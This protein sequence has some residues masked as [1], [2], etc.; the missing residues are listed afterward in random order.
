M[1]I[2]FNNPYIQ[3]ILIAFIAALLAAFFVYLLKLIKKSGSQLFSKFQQRKKEETGLEI[4][5]CTLEEKTL[6]ISHPWMKEDQTLNGILVPINFEMR[7]V[8]EREE[9]EIYVKSL[10]RKKSAPRLLILG[11]PG[12]GKTIAMRVIAR[13]MWSI[14][15]KIRLVPVILNFSDIKN[16]TNKKELEQKIIE[17]LEYYQ[18]EKGKKDDKAADKFI[19]ENLYS[20][21]IILLFDG[22]DEIEKSARGSV[23]EFL[24]HFL[25]THNNIPAI[26]SSRIA[27]YEKELAFDELRPEKINIAPFTPFAILKFLSQWKFE[28]GKSSH[29]LFEMINGKAH[30]SELASNPLMLTIITFLYSLPK[31]VLPDNRVQFYEQCTRALLEEWDRSQ[32]RERANKFESHQKIAVLNRVAYEHVSIAGETDELIYEDKIY[33]VIREEMTRLSLRVEEYPSMREEIVLNS[34][35][36]QH[37]PPTDYRFPHRTFMEFFAAN[38]LVTEQS[39]QD[40]LDLYKQDPGK[41]KEVLLLYM[42]L[43][44]N[45]EYSNLILEYLKT[46]FESSYRENGKPNILVFN[47]LT[48]CAVPDPDLASEILSLA[49]KFLIH[50]KPQVELIEELGFIAANPR[51]KHS[52]N[53]KNILLNLLKDELDDDTFQQV[54]FSLLHAQDKSVDEIILKNLK[55]LN[56]KKLFTTLSSR[57]KYFIHKLFS[58]D[59]SINKKREIIE[60][61]REAGNFEILGSLLIESRDA[62]IRQ[63]SAYALF[64]MSKLDG[65]FEYLDNAEIGLLDDVTVKL[66]DEKFIEWDWKWNSPKTENGKKIAILICHVTAR[67]IAEFYKDFDEKSLEEVNN[68]FRYLTTGLLVEN[69]IPFHKFNL[70]NIEKATATLK[71]LKRHWKGRININSLWYKIWNVDEYGMFWVNS[72]KAFFILMLLLLYVAFVCLMAGFTLHDFYNYLFDGFTAIF[73]I[74]YV[75]VSYLLV[76]FGEAILINK[77]SQLYLLLMPF[78]I[79]TFL[80]YEK[81]TKLYKLILLYTLCL[82]LFFS[83]VPFHR[84]FYNIFFIIYISIIGIWMYDE[85][86]INFALINN[87]NLKQ[88]YFFL[89]RDVN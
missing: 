25:G 72:L 34:G 1:Q 18:F 38:Y 42:G 50:H 85:C 70:I 19:E 69:G 3:G 16:V 84:L 82:I 77:T 73:L 37:I 6:R 81:F 26:I 75:V 64:R 41:W 8:T 60:G 76:I 62:K 71:G 58:L 7:G 68:W 13:T 40:V 17:K 80:I 30:L 66:L 83:L 88:V 51:W 63:L 86:N 47:A 5:R 52:K 29:E 57:G 89:Y 79:I 27:V 46:E 45:K 22:Y 36:L 59:L 48:E 2:D 20:G 31:Y 28:E 55:R 61:I 9:L 65:F 24:N 21:N 4:Y 33:K 35:L 10:F 39:Y 74:L 54:I 12:S 11:K 23:A 53:A 44:K 14:D 78:H 32:K 15:E 43:I 49:E 56:L 67:C 87:L